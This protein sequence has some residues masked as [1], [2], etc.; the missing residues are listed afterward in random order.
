MKRRSI[1]KLF[2]ALTGIL[3][4]LGFFIFTSASMGLLARGDITISRIAFNQLFFGLI[5]GS[6]ALLITLRIDY[7]IWHKYSFYIFIGTIILTLLVFIPGV[8]FSHGGATR[9]LNLGPLSFQPSELLKLGFVFYFSAWLSGVKSHVES[10]KYGVLPLLGLFGIV[11]IILLLQPDTDTFLII[12]L[13]GLAMFVTA[14]ARWSHIVSLGVVA[15]VGIGSLAL[16]KPYIK[17]RLMTFLNPASDPL[18]AGYQIQQSLI[19]IGSG[20]LT[21]RGFGQSV[22]KFNFLPEPVGDSI[23]AVFAEEWG[24]IG[25]IILIGI[26]LAFGLRGL[27]IA[28]EAPALFPKLV[29]TGI[30]TMIVMQSFINIASM[31]G[32]F[33]LSGTPLIFVSQGG[34]ALLVALASIGIVLNISRSKKTLAFRA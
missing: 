26:F 22:Q 34:S 9:W 3:V 7:A 17:E 2:F 32:V 18:G 15:V 13:T 23:F 28:S 31:L 12:I 4:F 20:K 24:F 29:V 14:G 11:G 25:S 33:P 5:L 27:K 30:I 16:I 19:A 21:G 10:I 1:D 6:I 8:G